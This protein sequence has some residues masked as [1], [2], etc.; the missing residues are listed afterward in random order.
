MLD[1]RYADLIKQILG[2]AVGGQ[3]SLTQPVATPTYQKAN[4]DL[5]GGLVG[6]HR[7]AVGKWNSSPVE[8]G[9]SYGGPENPSD[10]LRK[11][12]PL[13]PDIANTDFRAPVRSDMPGNTWS[14]ASQND[15]RIRQKKAM[16]ASS[17]GDYEMMIKGLLSQLL[18]RLFANQGGQN[19]VR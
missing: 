13:P 14:P 15:L 2:S 18:T 4:Q 1:A 16:E 10:L 11:P 17:G 19:G 12:D 6:E 9:R 5:L 7:K 8:P 3:R